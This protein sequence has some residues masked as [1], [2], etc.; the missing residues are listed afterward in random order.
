MVRAPEAMLPRTE[1]RSFA[2]GSTKD[3]G[4]HDGEHGATADSHEGQVGKAASAHGHRG[5]HA[6]TFRGGLWASCSETFPSQ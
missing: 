4:K 6:K 5:D 2:G 3:V 1:G